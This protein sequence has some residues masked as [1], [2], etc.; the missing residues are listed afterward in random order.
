MQPVEFRVRV[1][2]GPA[3]I[4]TASRGSGHDD[5]RNPVQPDVKRRHLLALHREQREFAELRQDVSVIKTKGTVE[6]VS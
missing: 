5:F 3:V 2:H 4:L 6:R 1:A